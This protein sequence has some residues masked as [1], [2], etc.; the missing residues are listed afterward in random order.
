MD[1]TKT[2]GN[3]NQITEV[4]LYVYLL[5]KFFFY[6]KRDCSTKD[7]RLV[8]IDSSHKYRVHTTFDIR[9]IK[10]NNF[11]IHHRDFNNVTYAEIDSNL[12]DDYVTF[13]N[14]NT[15][16]QYLY[17]SKRGYT[18]N[19]RWVNFIQ[20]REYVEHSMPRFTINAS[21]GQMI[22][23]SNILLNQGDLS[24]KSFLAFGSFRYVPKYVF[25]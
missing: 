15:K 25:Y 9:N 17:R 16:Y 4:W 11:S 2:P 24:N 12:S 8:L 14:F 20:F 10:I 6:S 18:I 23:H 21:S 22:K 13:Y 5:H 7:G 3:S 19:F 1:I